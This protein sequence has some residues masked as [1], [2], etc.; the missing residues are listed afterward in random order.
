MVVLKYAREAMMMTQRY[1]PRRLLS[2]DKAN[3]EL[4]T[5][6]ENVGEISKNTRFHLTKNGAND[7]ARH[8]A[9]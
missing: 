3:K 1:P 7:R 9:N 4:R 5:K 8:M 2:M 6:N